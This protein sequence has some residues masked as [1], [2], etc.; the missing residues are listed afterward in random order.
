MS[1]LRAHDAAPLYKYLCAQLDLPLDNALLSTM[2]AA[3]V[4]KL[5]SF[6]TLLADAD[7]NHGDVEIRQVLYDKATYLAYIGDKDAALVALDEC[8]KKTVA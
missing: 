8:E 5:A 6:P 4:T 2:T 7:E 1:I 3:N